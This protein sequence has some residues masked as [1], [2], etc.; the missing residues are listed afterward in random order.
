MVEWVNEEELLISNQVRVEIVKWLPFV[1]ELRTEKEV[2]LNSGEQKTVFLDPLLQ[3]VL[4]A[5]SD[6]VAKFPHDEVAFEG[7]TGAVK[8]VKECRWSS[9]HYDYVRVVRLELETVW[10]Y[11]MCQ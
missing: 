8:E 5:D 7:A 4:V 10:I 9:V 6:E 2:A 3:V 1:V 11:W